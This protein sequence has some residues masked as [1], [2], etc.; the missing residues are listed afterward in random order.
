MVIKIMEAVEA[1]QMIETKDTIMVGGFL[2]CGFPIILIEALL[3][4]SK[5]AELTIISSDTGNNE[6]PIAKLIEDGRVKKVYASYIGANKQT[7]NMLIKNPNS[8]EL[9]PQG[10]L[11]ERIRAG[12]AG[13][14]GILTPVGIGTVVQEGKQVIK[15][16]DCDYLLEQ[17]LKADVAL[18]KAD[19]ADAYGNLFIHGTSR[20]FNEV[21]AT[22]AQYVIAQVD[23]IVAVGQL[24]ADKIT[25]PCIYIDAIV[26][27]GH[28]K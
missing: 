16:N 5:S 21:M 12:G 20:N 10:T 15:V 25:I 14:G 17:P 11:A 2:Q 4:G 13:L 24:D 23:K 8:V 28:D 9:V 7:S 19:I 3:E 18:I 22:A 27:V 1:I 6:L 26:E